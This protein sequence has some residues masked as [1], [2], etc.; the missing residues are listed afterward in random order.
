MAQCGVKSA[1]VLQAERAGLVQRL[2]GA[3]G[4]GALGAPLQLA[5]PLALLQPRWPTSFCH[6]LSL[7]LPEP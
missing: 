2:A 4:D 1:M 3:P 5:G 6:S 7:C